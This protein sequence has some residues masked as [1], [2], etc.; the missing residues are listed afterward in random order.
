MRMSA[1]QLVSLSLVGALLL[2]CLGGIMR[3]WITRRLGMAWLLLWLGVGTAIAYP[4]LTVLVAH[5]LG[6]GRGADLVFYCAI[7]MTLVGFF[8]VYLRLRRLEANV[9]KIV[10]HIALKEAVPPKEW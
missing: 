8:L 5:V 10:R 1:F 3:G 7:L 6:I 9:T 2:L 4:R